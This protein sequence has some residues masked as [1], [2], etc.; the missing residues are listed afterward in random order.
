MSETTEKCSPAYI[1]WAMK[2]YGNK[3]TKRDQLLFRYGLMFGG[4]GIALN[5]MPPEDYARLEEIVEECIA[6]GKPYDSY[7]PYPDDEN[8]LVDY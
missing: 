1:D 3:G 4:D 6:T 5:C 2:K 8:I 7:M